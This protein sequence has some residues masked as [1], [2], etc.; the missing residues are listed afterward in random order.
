MR[1]MLV[2]PLMLLAISAPQAGEGSEP[3]AEEIAGAVLQRLGGREAWEA[4]RS[5][6]WDFFGSRTHHWDKHTGEA[7]LKMPEQ[8]SDSGEQERRLA[9]PPAAKMHGCASRAQPA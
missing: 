5:V 6:R 1:T 4:T 3:Q 9:R 2:V 7:R 8:K